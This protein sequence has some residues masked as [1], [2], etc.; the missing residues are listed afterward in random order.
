M[1][2]ESDS[3][4]FEVELQKL[5]HVENHLIDLQSELA[6]EVSDGDLGDL[7]SEHQGDTQQ[8]IDRLEG[9][10]QTLDIESQQRESPT[11]EGI[12]TEHDAAS[13][14]QDAA[15][16]DTLDLGIAMG[17]ER[18]EIT[19]LETLQRL[20]TEQDLPADVIEPL[21]T[22]QQEAEDAL[23]RMQSMADS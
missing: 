17:I 10:F 1:A 19:S 13:D 21:E 20:A 8:Q 18:L 3:D 7:F 22:T 14:V 15:I 12:L 6:D 4:V 16:R 9:V 5:Y 11:M 23:Q 2:I